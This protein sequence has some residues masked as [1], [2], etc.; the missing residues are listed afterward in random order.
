MA[1]QPSSK[2]GSS[3]IRFIMIDAEIPEGD[4]SQITAAIHNALKPT[5]IIQQR[6]SAQSTT[7][8]L[9]N[10]AAAETFDADIIDIDQS[11]DAPA[12][13]K[14]AR[15]SKPRKPTTPDVLE[16]D[17]MS[18]V[19]LQTFADAHPATGEPE[20]YLVIAA[21][22]KE[23]RD[24]SSITTAHVYTAYRSLGWSVAIEDFGWPLRS[25]KKDKLMSSPARGEYVINH[26]GI[27]RVNKLGRGE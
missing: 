7:S 9:S 10:E 20:R 23:H 18:D 6:F 2:S 27:G 17:L 19:S 22:F 11:A 21:W 16:L 14:P 1:K 3:R 13:Q 8:A 12:P 4:L 5:T 26:L 24:T 15:V 25:L